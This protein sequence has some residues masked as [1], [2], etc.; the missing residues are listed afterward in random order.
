M[1]HTT[2]IN[3]LKKTSVVAN[4]GGTSISPLR[5]LLRV[6]NNCT[7]TQ[8]M[9]ASIITVLRIAMVLSDSVWSIG[10]E[11]SRAKPHPLVHVNFTLGSMPWGFGGPGFDV[12]KSYAGRVLGAAPFCG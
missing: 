4:S 1:A 12:F 2:K 6:I 9:A 8:P 7:M 3:R 10:I 11:I 5:S